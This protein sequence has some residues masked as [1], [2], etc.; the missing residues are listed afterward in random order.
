VIFS[1]AFEMS[2]GAI[3]WLYSPEITTDKG[4]SIAVAVNWTCS[5]IIGQVT[6]YIFNEWLFNYGFLMF[7]GLCLFFFVINI[8]WMKETKG[9][10]DRECK[11]LYAP[12][13]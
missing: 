1:T 2:F 12:K 4:M 9:K 3:F 13:K 11:S 10:S 6:P 8:F 5:V 7:G